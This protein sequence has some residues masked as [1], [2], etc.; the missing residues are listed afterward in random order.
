[1]NAAAK[2]EVDMMGALEQHSDADGMK[3]EED[4]VM[5]PKQFITNH[6]CWCIRLLYIV[7]VFFL[8]I[9]F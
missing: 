8:Q 7:N 3:G 1:M 2:H 4:G 9:T 6:F 5:R